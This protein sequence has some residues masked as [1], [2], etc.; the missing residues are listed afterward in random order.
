MSAESS[1]SLPNSALSE[2]LDLRM[3]ADSEAISTAVDTI[4][5]TLAQLEV[6]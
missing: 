3:P 5:E 2:L 6:P 1:S 4:T